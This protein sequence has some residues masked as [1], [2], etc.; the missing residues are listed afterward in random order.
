MK[1]SISRSRGAGLSDGAAGK[2]SIPLRHHAAPESAGQDATLCR[3]CG[4]RLELY[5]IEQV[6]VV[7]CPTCLECETLQAADA[8]GA[9]IHP[10]AMSVTMP[11][12]ALPDRP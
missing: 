2:A 1:C 5:Q 4:D 3:R 11:V 7:I 12:E 8:M 6:T 10:I 9:P